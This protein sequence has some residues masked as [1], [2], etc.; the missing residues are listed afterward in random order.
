MEEDLEVFIMSTASETLEEMRQ[1]V[2]VSH[3]ICIERDK[4]VCTYINRLTISTEIQR[5]NSN[6]SNNKKPFCVNTF[7]LISDFS[8]TQLKINFSLH[9]FPH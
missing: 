4:N 5:N 1:T 3:I 2:N 7:I 9:F 8:S 6:P